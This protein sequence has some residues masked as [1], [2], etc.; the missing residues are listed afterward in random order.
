MRV[1]VIESDPSIGG[2]LAELLADEGHVSDGATTPDEGLARARA[3]PWDACVTDG[4]SD[5]LTAV[6]RAY[7]DDLGSCCPVILLSAR[8][9][10]RWARPADLGVAAVVPKPFVLDDLLG[11]LAAVTSP[12]AAC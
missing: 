12:P 10:A 6:A 8:S 11:A 4:F 1:L 7:L 9:W 5:D 2:L 3:A